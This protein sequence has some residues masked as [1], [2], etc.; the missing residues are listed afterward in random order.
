MLA[1]K[2]SAMLGPRERAAQ[3]EKCLASRSVCWWCFD[4]LQRFCAPT[5]CSHL[6]MRRH[7]LLPETI[8]LHT[9]PHLWLLRVSRLSA[10]PLPSCPASS[11][12][13]FTRL[14]HDIYTISI[15]CPP[16][17]PPT[18]HINHRALHPTL[19][20]AS[21]A[22]TEPKTHSPLLSPV[23]RPSTAVVGPDIPPPLARHLSLVT[24]HH[25][26][27]AAISARPTSSKTAEPRCALHSS[28]T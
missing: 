15:V 17:C 28:T 1:W 21:T 14:S 27:T 16:D 7:G 26:R 4:H 22:S 19:N 13:T 2:R 5:G 11:S 10:W 12:G 9:N 3:S 24:R 18:S 25:H 6:P 20:T 8:T 23:L